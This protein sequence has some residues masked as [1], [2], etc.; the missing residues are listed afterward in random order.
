MPKYQAP[1]KKSPGKFTPGALVVAA[2]LLLQ[3]YD[4]G[5]LRTLGTFGD[6]EAHALT[7]GK[8]LEAL[9]L[10]RREVHENIRTVGLL[11]KAETLGITE[12]LDCSFCHLNN[13]LFCVCAVRKHGQGP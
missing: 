1:D 3:G 11:N 4:V 9:R 5:G 2:V 13:S 12:P 8:G 7:L 10:D 6:L